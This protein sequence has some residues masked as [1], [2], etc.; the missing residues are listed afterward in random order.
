MTTRS[1][2][3]RA[4]AAIAVS[5]GGLA[6]AAPAA[7]APID[8]GHFHDTGSELLDH[9]C[10]DISLVHTWDI[11]GSYLGRVKGP[12]GQVYYR[13]RSSGTHVF[14]NTAT[15]RTYT[16]TFSTA[17]HDAQI[18][19][20][21]DGTLTIVVQGSGNE[22]WYAGGKLVLKN[23]GNLRWAILVDD[24]GTPDDP[25]DDEFLE[26]LGLVRDSTG[27]NDTDGRFFCDDIAEFTS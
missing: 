25:F 21:G 8:S 24:G 11:T 9:F 6:G 7:A 26:D 22:K 19:D 15:G 27:R 16:Q 3:T 23:P 13:D 20:N 10:G 1:N 17:T 2:I 12:D 4:A 5:L 18:T 14:I